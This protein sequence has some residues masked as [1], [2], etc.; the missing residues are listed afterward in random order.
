MRHVKSKANVSV[1]QSQRH[2]W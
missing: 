2:T 1:R